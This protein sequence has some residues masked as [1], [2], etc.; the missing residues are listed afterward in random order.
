MNGGHGWKCINKESERF[1]AQ[2]AFE[3]MFSRISYN[4]ST[5]Q[6]IGKTDSQEDPQ[7][8]G[9]RNGVAKVLC[10]CVWYMCMCC[11]CV[12]CVL[13][14]SDVCVVCRV[15]VVGVYVLYVCVV[16]VLCMSGVCVWCV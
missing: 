4:H 5:T 2:G 16:C 1:R 14:T 6:R 13:C 9:L 12:V 11:M 7:Q 3:Q 10:V 8:Q 15:C